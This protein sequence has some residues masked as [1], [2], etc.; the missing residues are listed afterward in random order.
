MN[1]S[2]L[3]RVRTVLL[4]LVTQGVLPGAVALV[5]HRGRTVLHEA[6]GL[7]RPANPG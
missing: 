4:D 6:V 3:A 1:P 2:A 7:Q 5:Q